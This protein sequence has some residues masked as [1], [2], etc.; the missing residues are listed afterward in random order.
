MDSVESLLNTPLAWPALRYLLSQRVHA[1]L[2][3]KQ[4]FTAFD[5]VRQIHDPCGR[6][7][8]IQGPFH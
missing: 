7:N 8:K 2:D 4:V 6:K 5:T 3:R 1:G